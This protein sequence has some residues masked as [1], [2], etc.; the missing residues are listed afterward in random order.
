MLPTSPNAANDMRKRGGVLVYGSGKLAAPR[1]WPP[2]SAESPSGRGFPTLGRHPG[3]TRRALGL[4]TES[5]GPKATPTVALAPPA[6]ILS[7]S[8]ALWL[9]GGLSLTGGLLSGAF[10]RLGR[11]LDPLPTRHAPNWQLRPPPPRRP[12]FEG[13]GEGP[14]GTGPLFRSPPRLTGLFRSD[15]EA[16]VNACSWRR[17]LRPDS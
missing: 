3:P 14:I 16:E 2:R 6:A 8:R 7:N 13:G 17:R 1:P 4:E 10:R 11:W 12:R 5:W 15:P 9:T